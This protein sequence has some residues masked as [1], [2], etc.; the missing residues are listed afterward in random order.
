MK[1]QRKKRSRQEWARLVEEQR[2]SGLSV[3]QFCRRESVAEGSFYNWRSRLADGN[4]SVPTA[5]QPE[6]FIDMGRMLSNSPTSTDASPWVV[7]LD[8][9]GG[10]K[11]TLHRV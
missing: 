4:E 7:T 9:G 11:L 3:T 6:S 2:R 1:G 8:L 10:F 5:S